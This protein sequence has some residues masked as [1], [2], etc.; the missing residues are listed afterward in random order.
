MESVLK[1]GD[2]VSRMVDALGRRDHL[3]RAYLKALLSM[4]FL[5]LAAGSNAGIT[6]EEID[7]GLEQIMTD[8]EETL[9]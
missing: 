8:A 7:E 3:L 6:Q 1:E 5:E 4:K 2:R 9:K